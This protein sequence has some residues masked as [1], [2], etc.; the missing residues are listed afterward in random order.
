MA[1]CY[2]DPS[3]IFRGITAAASLKRINDNSIQMPRT[4]LPRHHCRGLI[5]A[6]REDTARQRFIRRI[7]RGITAAASLKRETS[8]ENHSR[9]GQIFRGITAAA[10]LKQ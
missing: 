6:A 4:H 1:I 2:E 5:E 10:S 9:F 3:R 7:F 8:I